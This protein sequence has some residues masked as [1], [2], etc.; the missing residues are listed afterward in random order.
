LGGN[1]NHKIKGNKW[2]NERWKQ[3]D[4][5]KCIMTTL[6]KVFEHINHTK[7]WKLQTNEKN[8]ANRKALRVGIEIYIRINKK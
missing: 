8:R 2:R 5:L 3:E 1:I 6:K 7:N 4:R